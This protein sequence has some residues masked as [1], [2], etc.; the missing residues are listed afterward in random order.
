[1]TTLHELQPQPLWDYFQ[2]LTRVPRPSH[3]ETAVQEHI[4]AEAQKLGLTAERDAAGNIRVIKPG[5]RPGPGVILQGHL[6]MVAQK[7]QDTVHL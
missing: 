6:D 5:K 2:G 4:L 7:N 1:M 3:E